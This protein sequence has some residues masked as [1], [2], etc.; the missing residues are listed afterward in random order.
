MKVAPSRT[1][2]ALVSQVSVLPVSLV[3]RIILVDLMQQQK[4]EGL[5]CFPGPSQSHTNPLKLSGGLLTVD[6]F[7]MRAG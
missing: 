6:P 3:E 2:Y 7:A 4:A 5:D 1:D